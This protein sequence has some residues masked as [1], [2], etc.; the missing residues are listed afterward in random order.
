MVLTADEQFFMNEVI[1]ELVHSRKKFPDPAG[2]MAA[3]CEETGEVA[4]AMLSESDR[5]V[6][7]ECVQV[8]ATALRIAIEGDPTLRELRGKLG[9]NL[10]KLL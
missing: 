2:V 5:R 6:Y 4:K 7:A 9:L 3:L 10:D 1:I 8:A